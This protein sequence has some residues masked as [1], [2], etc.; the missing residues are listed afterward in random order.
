MK[1]TTEKNR[2][3]RV[4][5][6]IKQKGTYLLSLRYGNGSGPINTENKCAIRTLLD[7]SHK[8]GTLVMPQR[9]KDGWSN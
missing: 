8:L 9:G 7:G 3:I 6:N 5:V 4:H 2:Q 1:T